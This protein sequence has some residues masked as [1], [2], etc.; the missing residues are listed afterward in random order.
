MK[1]T[2]S[3]SSK[4]GSNTQNDIS[5]KIFELETAI[6]SYGI[7]LECRNDFTVFRETAKKITDL[8]ELTGVFDDQVS[9]IG[10]ENGFWIQGKNQYGE[11]VHRQAIRHDDLAGTSLAN[12]WITN[13]QVH[14]PAGYDIDIEESD[15]N[16]A[17]VADTITGSVCYH[18]EFWL[19]LPY[20]KMEVA[21]F[22]SRYC[23]LLGLLQFSPNVIYGTMPPKLIERGWSVR[24]GYLHIHPWAPRWRI[25][26]K[27]KYYDEY[28]V[29]ISSSELVNLWTAD[30]RDIDVLGRINF[31]NYDGGTTTEH[32]TGQ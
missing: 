19:D 13:P 23:I 16:T 29:W 5:R 22:L 21:S 3:T 9:E 26:G 10:P 24:A 8:A 1:A 15:F 14:A 18:G 4:F 6:Q 27:S 25:R 11:V 7:Q 20:R 17:P 31:R 32:V 28:L 12:H 30:E 2:V